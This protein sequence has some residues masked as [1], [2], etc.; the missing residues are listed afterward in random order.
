M[1][2]KISRV[3]DEIKSGMSE[4]LDKIYRIIKE[5][6]CSKLKSWT[7]ELRDLAPIDNVEN[8]DAYE[9]T[10]NWVF[11][12]KRIKNV[13]LSGPYGSGKSSIIESYLKNNKGVKRA[14]LKVSLASFTSIGAMSEE[15]EESTKAEVSE[16]EIESAILKQLFYAVKPD[17]IPLSRYRRLHEPSSWSKFKNY[18]SIVAFIVL[19]MAAIAPNIRGNVFA[20]F[21]KFLDK[22]YFNQAIIRAIE[23]AS[24]SL[25]GAA[26]IYLLYKNH[27]FGFR[28]SEIKVISN[29][30]MKN[31]NETKESAFNRNLDEIVYFFEKTRFRTVFFEDLD[32][33]NNPKIFVHLRELNNLLNNDPLI[34]GKPIKFVYA[35][36]DDIFTSED[37]VKFFDFIILVVPIISE[38]NSSAT[39]LKKFKNTSEH[40]INH[41][42]IF[43]IHPFISDA[44]T[45]HS[46]VNDFLIY[47]K[48]LK[49]SQGVDI[50]DSKIFAI[51]LLKNRCPHLFYRIQGGSLPIIDLLRGEYNS[52]DSVEVELS[53][54]DNKLISLLIQ[55]GYID[56]ECEAY[57]NYS[58]DGKLTERDKTF[59]L[60]VQEMGRKSILDNGEKFYYE[61]DNVRNVLER[62]DESDFDKR[63][64]INYD[65]LEYLLKKCRLNDKETK[66]SAHSFAEEDARLKRLIKQLVVAVEN[67]YEI[68]CFV[69][70]FI[71]QSSDAW[72]LIRFLAVEWTGMVK[73]ITKSNGYHRFLPR[74]EYGRNLLEISK[75]TEHTE[76]EIE[77]TDDEIRNCVHEVLQGCDLEVIKK[78]NTERCLKLYIDKNFKVLQS[79]CGKEINYD[80]EH[81]RIVLKE[82][83]VKIIEIPS[84]D[85]STEQPIID[86]IKE[87]I[88][89]EGRFEINSNTIQAVID[90]KDKKGSLR[91]QFKR[92]PI[93]TIMDL[94]YNQLIDY[95]KCE[96][97]IFIK[98]VVLKMDGLQ[99]D[100]KDVI[101]VLRLL[102]KKQLNEKEMLEFSRKLI[103]KE[104]FSLNK[105]AECVDEEG[106]ISK[107]S[108]SWKPIWDMLLENNKVKVSWENVNAYSRRYGFS[109]TLK[110][111]IV[112]HAKDLKKRRI[113]SIIDQAILE[114]YRKALKK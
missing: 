49:D 109:D 36:R 29:I 112:G 101:H 96:I 76:H 81:L 10:L 65:L 59:L 48:I 102:K 34:T 39:L 110:N 72:K 86:E 91:S 82:L 79:A 111:Y 1:R 89:G 37:R 63:E 19:I 67:E 46:T 54:N 17:V 21:D 16:E 60:R 83:G 80:F 61:L 32:R 53:S 97:D 100:S 58:L 68:W 12:N 18:F 106:Q 75:V 38:I 25:V 2:S 11:Q 52:N 9:Q 47:K 26:V 22:R 95:V 24:V 69:R 105:I 71:T 45:L 31:E 107:I 33:L 4:I 8:F 70:K 77:L 84:E 41:E 103:E 85:I 94:D 42:F 98:N 6:N 64:V 73:Y 57:V 99:D 78:Q 62:L 74:S 50:V 15:A 7:D 113:D 51:M 14:A 114:F 108:K 104:D 3:L 90:Y 27:F 55:K 43:D 92:K 35:V 5:K 28:I 88:F 44:R 66:V 23:T 40:G 87:I 13:A 20:I 93:S 56:K 30:T